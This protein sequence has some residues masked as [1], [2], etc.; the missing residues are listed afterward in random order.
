MLSSWLSSSLRFLSLVFT[1][2]FFQPFP[3]AERTFSPA[4]T[5]QHSF[6]GFS[7][8]AM[9]SYIPLTYR[10]A[11]CWMLPPD[12]PGMTLPVTECFHKSYRQ[13]LQNTLFSSARCC[14][15]LLFFAA[16]RLEKVSAMA[17]LWLAPRRGQAEP[18]ELIAL[19]R[20]PGSAFSL[21]EMRPLLRTRAYHTS[22]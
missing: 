21:W 4:F 13:C 18:L 12:S 7:A 2:A 20:A 11:P 19:D 9:S 17:C 8:S 15:A 14:C 22:L 5:T 1:L 16:T 3:T 6:L 10:P